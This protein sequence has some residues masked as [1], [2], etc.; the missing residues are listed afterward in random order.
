LLAGIEGEKY[1]IIIFL[2]AKVRNLEPLGRMI[3]LLMGNLTR[4][5]KCTDYKA[6]IEGWL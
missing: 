2:R 1:L 6:L 4:L 5:F 3:N